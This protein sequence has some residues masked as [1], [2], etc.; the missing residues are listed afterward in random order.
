MTHPWWWMIAVVSKW[1]LVNF[2]VDYCASCCAGGVSAIDVITAAAAIVNLSLSIVED[3]ELSS[4][5][6]LT[7]RN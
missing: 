7:N 4:W 5:L 3:V 1:W 2:L 6:R